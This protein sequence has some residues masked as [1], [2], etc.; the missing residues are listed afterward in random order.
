MVAFDYI[1]SPEKAKTL[2]KT[3]RK[4]AET[5]DQQVNYDLSPWL[6]GTALFL[7]MLVYLPF[8]FGRP[9]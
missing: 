5:R 2:I 8:Q 4:T 3:L 9:H 7:L 6:A 1:F